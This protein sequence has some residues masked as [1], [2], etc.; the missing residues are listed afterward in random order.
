MLIGR[1]TET[2]KL[3]RNLRNGVHTVIFGL[4]GTG[5]SALL[6]EA[7]SR[8][9]DNF[10]SEP[11][12]VYVSDC[13]N[14]RKLL[15]NALAGLG[16]NSPRAS[17]GNSSNVETRRV[18]DLRNALVRHSRDRN[19]CLL[20]DH[21]PRL[22]H[23]LEHLLE[24]L[25]QHCTLACA[26]TSGRD[27]YDLYYWKFDKIEME[28]L[29]AK[30]A[31]SW[32]ELELGNLGYAGTLK[33]GIG[34]EILRLTGGNPGTIS[35]TLAIIRCQP[36]RLDDPIRVRRMFIDGRLNRFKKIGGL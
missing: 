1:K 32:I 24:I 7:Q 30:I 35:E 23:R 34:H 25:E 4:A 12:I 22:H 31:V 15:E 20:L 6:R 28:N 10:E 21:L 14:R 27:A 17:R 3:I 29:P 2:D 13:R 9:L 11:F 18:Q 26:V 8:L 16:F 5:K 36:C 19:L 33:H